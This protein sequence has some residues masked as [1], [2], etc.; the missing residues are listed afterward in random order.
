MAASEAITSSPSTP[1]KQIPSH[2]PTEPTFTDASHQ[3][4]PTIDADPVHLTPRVENIEHPITTSIP[5]AQEHY[6]D[7]DDDH[8]APTTERISDGATAEINPHL[9]ASLSLEA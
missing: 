3:H 6:Q 9:E 5:S 8:D 7:H 2:P 4:S 1:R